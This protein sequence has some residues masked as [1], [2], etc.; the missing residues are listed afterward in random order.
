MMRVILSNHAAITRAMTDQA[1]NCRARKVIGI[2]VAIYA[3][4]QGIGFAIPVDRARKVV[5]DILRIGEVHA[6]WIGA[7]TATITP[8]EAKR[9]GHA[10]QR[11]ALVVRVFEDSPADRA[12]MG[13][14]SLRMILGL[15]GDKTQDL[16]EQVKAKTASI[17]GYPIVTE[18]TW[19]V[20]EDP[21]AVQRRKA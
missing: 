1:P 10:T 18:S 8:E 14:A 9:Q 15:G 20:E 17:Q 7:V 5:Q 16:L 6:A 12:A 3:Q 4:G 11:G 21:K 19:T 13:E 2:N